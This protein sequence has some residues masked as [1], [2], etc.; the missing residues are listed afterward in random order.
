MCRRL[1]RFEAVLLTLVL[2][3]CEERTPP[4]PSAEDIARAHAALELVLTGLWIEEGHGRALNIQPEGDGFGVRAVT[5][6]G[7]AK[8]RVRG[9]RAGAVLALDPPLAGRTELHLCR[10]GTRQGRCSSVGCPAGLPPRLAHVESGQT[11]GVGDRPR[12]G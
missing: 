10:F 9:V 1:C 5:M 11:A 6:P 3:A 2:S 8:E 12:G 7:G 4:V